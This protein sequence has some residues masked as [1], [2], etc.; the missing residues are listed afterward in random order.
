MSFMSINLY[1]VYLLYCTLKE[2]SLVKNYILCIISIYFYTHANNTL[3]CLLF[4]N[5]KI[6]ELLKSY[7]LI[8]SVI[9]LI[10]QN[11][12]SYIFH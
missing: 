6:C 4:E 9:G 5:M 10:T 2:Q 8:S 3:R 1:F 7:A 11:I 12:T